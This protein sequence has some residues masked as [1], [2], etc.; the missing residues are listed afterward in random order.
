MKTRISRLMLAALAT[1]GAFTFGLPTAANGSAAGSAAA[2]SEST[3]ET[4]VYFQHHY[5]LNASG[6]PSDREQFYNLPGRPGA[7]VD[8]N[9][10]NLNAYPCG[11]RGPA[12][13]DQ[14]NVTTWGVSFRLWARSA[15]L[16]RHSGCY[17]V[18][19]SFD[20]LVEA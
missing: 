2:R 14:I 10:V 13:I 16:F 1:A 12:G 17:A 6:F 9:T 7:V 8:T 4:R 18:D 3:T 20:Y 15:G 5:E 19:V 11:F